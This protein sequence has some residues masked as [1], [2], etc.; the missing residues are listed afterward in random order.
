MG[1]SEQYRRFAEQ[2]LEIARNSA[3]PQT[4]SI[5]RHMAQ[6]WQRLAYQ[7]D[8]GEGEPKDNGD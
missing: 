5:M 1:R 4:Q 6:V 3:D 2:C 8:A 7:I